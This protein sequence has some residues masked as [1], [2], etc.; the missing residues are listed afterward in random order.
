M[1]FWRKLF[2]RRS[3]PFGLFL[4]GCAVVQIPRDGYGDAIARLQT[5]R[6]FKALAALVFG[7]PRGTDLVFGNAIAVLSAYTVSVS[8]VQSSALPGIAGAAARRIDI[9]VSGPP[10][11]DIA[12]SGY[13]TNY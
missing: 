4:D 9:N 11:V 6:D 7:L 12:L 8:V 1:S 3:V 5:F 13:R 2:Q 10:N